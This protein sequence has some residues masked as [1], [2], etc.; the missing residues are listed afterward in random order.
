MFVLRSRASAIMRKKQTL[1][2]KAGFLSQQKS[3]FNHG[4]DNDDEDAEMDQGE[5]DLPFY[6]SVK[7]TNMEG[8]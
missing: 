2:P 8:D 7:C 1:V 5:K 4:S 3:S 6:K